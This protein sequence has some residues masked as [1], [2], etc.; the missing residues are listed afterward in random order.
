LTRVSL[1]SACALMLWVALDVAALRAHA[2]S[3]CSLVSED[4]LSVVPPRR[5]AVVT[6]R[7]S[8]KQMLFLH[9]SEGRSHPLGEDVSATDLALAVGGGLRLPFYD[10]LQL[11][12][13]MPVRAQLRTLPSSD[14]ERDTA[15]ALGAGDASLFVRWSALFDDE[16][17]LLG[18][19]SSLQPSLDLFAGAKLPTGR[20]VEGPR[21]RDLARTMGD[22]S[23]ALVVG[24]SALKYIT[25][26][27]GARLSLRFVHPLARDSDPAG[28]GYE[29]FTPGDQLG[30]TAGYWLLEGM[31]WLFGAALDSTWTFASSARAPGEPERSLSNTE[32]HQTSIGLQLTRVLRMP[33]L[34]LTAGLGAD[35]PLPSVSANVSWEGVQASIA[36]RYHFLGEP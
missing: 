26:T 5:R 22:G 20:H 27:Q 21:A 35:L 11:H 33:D 16:R 12:G 13:T 32:M 3:C 2:Q 1:A 17:G 7:F 34:D 28:T 14:A 31:H 19:D 24:M 36:L 30:V 8:A 25:S 4:E 18:D 23:T 6:S 15:T 9:D 29:A 10:R